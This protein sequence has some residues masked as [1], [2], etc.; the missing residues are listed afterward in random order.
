MRREA[1]RGEVEGMLTRETLAKELYILR[2]ERVGA[3]RAESEPMW[4]GRGSGDDPDAQACFQ[5]ADAILALLRP[6]L[7]RLAHYVAQF[8]NPA[9]AFE[10]PAPELLAEA[11][12][13]LAEEWEVDDS[14]PCGGA[15]H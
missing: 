6:G 13:L 14:E 3:P 15:D 1:G 9:W 10:P 5:D 7:L 8:D 2:W 4:A 12:R 11:R